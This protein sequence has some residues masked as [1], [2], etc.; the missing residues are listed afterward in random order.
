VCLCDS[1]K[2]KKSRASFIIFLLETIDTIKIGTIQAP[3][4]IYVRYARKYTKIYEI[5]SN[6]IVIQDIQGVLHN[7]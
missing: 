2:F 7:S 5:L 3:L 4:N 6:M 1:Q